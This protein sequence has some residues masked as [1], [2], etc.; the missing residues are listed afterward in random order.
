MFNQNDTEKDTPD[1]DTIEETNWENANALVDKLMR[2][3]QK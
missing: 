2:V 3:G 1:V